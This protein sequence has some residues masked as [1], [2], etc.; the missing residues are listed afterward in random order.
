MEMS[1]LAARLAD[2]CG[3]IIFFHVHV[4]GVEM[5][6]DRWLIDLFQKGQ[7]FCY[8]VEHES[9]IAVNDFQA[10][11]DVKVGCRDRYLAQRCG[12]AVTVSLGIAIWRKI[13]PLHIGQPAEYGTA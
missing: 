9:F 13:K 1:K 5:E 3:N 11:R 6:F 7:A 12:A 4:V 2:R 8:G 10:D